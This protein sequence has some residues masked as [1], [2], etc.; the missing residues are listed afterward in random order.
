M[1]KTKKVKNFLK[2]VLTSEGKKCIIDKLTAR[3]AAVNRSLKIEQHE[4]SRALKSAKDLVKT[5]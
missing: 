1:K 2:K 5:L 4:K 3:G